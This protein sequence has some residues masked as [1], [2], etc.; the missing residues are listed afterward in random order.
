MAGTSDTPTPPAVL[1]LAGGLGTRLRSVVTDRPKVIATV[2]GRPFLTFLF[3]QLAENGF[4]SAS[5]C[6][7]FLAEQVQETLGREAAGLS[8]QY[9]SESTP[10]GTGGALRNALRTVDADEFLILNGDSFCDTSLTAFLDW[11][12]QRKGSASLLLAGVADTAR[13][14][15]VE[16]GSGD[17]ITAFREKGEQGAGTINAGIYLISRSLLEEIPEGKTVS[18]E[19]EV[20]PSWVER[21]VLHGYSA[22][23][24]RFIDIGTPETYSEAQTFFRGEAS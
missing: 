23:V 21:G 2:H 7:G 11:H 18:L 4:R 19:R 12:R 8:L 22:V 5:L 3:H 13:F 14:G 15:R 24:S 16:V 20:F 6:T 10:L 17:C 9:I 1:I